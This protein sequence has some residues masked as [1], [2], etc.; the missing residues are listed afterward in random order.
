MFPR[1]ILGGILGGM[2]RV[3]LST[4]TV[5]I[6]EINLSGNSVGISGENRVESLKQSLK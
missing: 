6:L 2:A 5:R 1:G 3:I 4:T